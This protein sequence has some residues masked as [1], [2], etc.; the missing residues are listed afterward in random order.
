MNI[1]ILK[2]N[3]QE[4]LTLKHLQAGDIGD[5]ARFVH[6][7]SC[8]IF[9]DIHVSI[10]LQVSPANRMIPHTGPLSRPPVP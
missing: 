3:I 10:V 9:R 1:E 6:A 5:N 2:R 4:V 7:D 8:E